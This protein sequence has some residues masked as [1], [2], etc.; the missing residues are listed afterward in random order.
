[1]LTLV[2]VLARRLFVLSGEIQDLSLLPSPMGTVLCGV[3]HIVDKNCRLVVVA[4]ALAKMHEI[5][6]RQSFALYAAQ[7]EEKLGRTRQG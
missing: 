5:P 3:L 7:K 1:M 6:L 2:D 4:V